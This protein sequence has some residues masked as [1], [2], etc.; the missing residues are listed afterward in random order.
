MVQVQVERMA[1]RRRV[2]AG[3]AS[4]EALLR[5]Q[6]AGVEIFSRRDTF[7]AAGQRW[8]PLISVT[9]NCFPTSSGKVRR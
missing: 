7:A 5:V 9:L 2:L 4:Q 1:P 8:S 6:P 3:Q